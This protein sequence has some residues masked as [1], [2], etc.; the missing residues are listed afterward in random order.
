MFDHAVDDPI[1]GGIEGLPLRRKGNAGTFG[2][3]VLSIPDSSG[4]PTPSTSQSRSEGFQMASWRRTIA[5]VDPAC[6]HALWN[7][8]RFCGRSCSRMLPWSGW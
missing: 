6:F 3:I 8:N 5:S 1:A 7:L 4:S 2:C